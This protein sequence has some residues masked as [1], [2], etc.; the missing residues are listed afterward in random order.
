MKREEGSKNEPKADFSVGVHA[1]IFGLIGNALLFAAKLTVGIL[2]GSIA[3]TAD[4]FNN[5][6]DGAS[7]AIT[8]AGY[9]LASRPADREHPFGHAR[10]EY[11]AAL[12]IAVLM[13]VIGAL[14][15]KESVVEIF[16]N[17]GAPNVR[18]Y[19]YIVLGLSVAMKGA[20]ATV[21]GV[22]YK[23]TGSLPMKAAAMDS[24]GDMFATSTAIL[25]A[26]LWDVSGRDLDGYFGTA[27]SLF[28][29]FTA[30][31]VLK[32][33]IS[34]LLGSA[35]LDS[36]VSAVR[37][38]ILS[39]PGVLGVHDITIHSYGEAR[40]Y[41]VA[42]IEVSASATLT[43]AHELVDRIERDILRDLGVRFVAHV[44][45]KQE[46][47][48]ATDLEALIRAFLFDKFAGASV[49]D[50]RVTREQG[51]ARVYLDAEIPWESA[52]TAEDLTAALKAFDPDF[53]YIVNVDRK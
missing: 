1:G 39:Y 38:K 48:S 8:V 32:E 34:P 14:F 52:L 44:D 43:D 31:R 3:V 29:L 36:L 51:D 15:L 22:S 40:A 4:A 16:Q 47:R 21:Y 23:R 6:S 25:S 10:F 27:I 28:I 42:H 37:E 49:H 20:Q 46:E 33:S 7:S 30:V 9:K 50:F 35:P 2:A 26:L 11:V 45:P 5:L 41:A 18:F 53:T 24:V 19:L 17:K 13:F 12:V